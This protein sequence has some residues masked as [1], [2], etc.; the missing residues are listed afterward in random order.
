MSFRP[1]FMTG[2][3]LS[4]AM[5]AM[6]WDTDRAAHMLGQERRRVLAWLKDE[7]DIPRWVPLFFTALTVDAARSKVIQADQFLIDSARAQQGGN[8]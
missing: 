2:G 6:G 8:R 7:H 3:Q 1:T 4:Q 5:T